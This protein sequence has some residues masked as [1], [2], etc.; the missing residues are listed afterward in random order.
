MQ[1]RT[2][3]AVALLSIAACSTDGDRIEPVGGREK[4]HPKGAFVRAAHRA[5]PDGKIEPGALMRMKHQRDAMLAAQ[6]TGSK[7][8]S[9]SVSGALT[10]WEWLGPG[11]VGGR[12]RG[13]VIHPNTPN[14][15]WVG[16]AGGGVWKTVDG[17]GTWLPLNDFLP[18]LAVGCMVM[19]PVD[20]DVIYVGTGEGG[21]F[22]TT[23]G[24]TNLAVMQG[25]GIFRTDDGGATFTQLASTASW[26][27]VSRIAVDPNDSQVLLAAT[28]DG[29][30]RTTDGGGAWT[31][32]STKPAMDVD[33][34]PTD[35]SKA[36]AGTDDEAL[37]SIDG[38]ASWLVA[39]GLPGPQTTDRVEI[40]YARSDPSIVFV[41]LSEGDI[42]LYRS[43]DGGASYA[44][45]Y[46]GN[47]I[48][49]YSKY[50]STMWV[51]PTDADVVV[52]GGVYPYRSTT[53]GTSPTSIIGSIHPDL[54][55]YAEHPNYDGVTN[56]TVYCSTDAGLWVTTNILA[57]SV[58]WNDLN[59]NLGITQFYG[60]AIH[61]GTGTVVG[62]TQDNGSQR[63]Q[64]ATDT[65]L[66]MFGGDGG[67]AASDPTNSNYFFGESQNLHIFRSTNG[68]LS[69]SYIYSSGS[70]PIIE[71]DP[72]FIAPFII[73]P[74]ENLRILAGGGELWRTNDNRASTV[75]WSSIKPPLNCSGEAAGNDDLGESHFAL[76]PPCNI[77]AIAVEPGNSDVI[78][79]G[80][81]NGQVFKTTNGTAV[82]PSWVDVDVGPQTLPGRFVGRI[83]IDPLDSDRVYVAFYG[84]T[85]DNLWLTEDGGVTWNSVTGAGAT[86]LPEAPVTSV[87]VHRTRA[88]IVYAGT[89]IGVYWSSDD[90]ATWATNNLGAGIA[91]IEELVWRNDDELMVVTHG[92]GI[93]LAHTL[94]GFE[95]YCTAG[96]SAAGCQATLSASGTPSASAAS[97]FQLQATGVEGNKDGLFFYGTNGRQLNPWGS[98]TSYQC[99]IPPVRRAG[100]LAATGTSGACDGSF[101][102]DLN[103]R[104]SAKPAHN[105]GSGAVVQAQ[106]WYRDPNNTSNQTT[107]LSDAIE[108]TV[109][110]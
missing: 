51:D 10:S 30:W 3:T 27:S 74:N 101:N 32:T 25:A 76:D 70:S 24:V 110:P 56:R 75:R 105:P 79:V 66:H 97:G 100:L 42:E 6:Q 1:R 93:Y 7:A 17:G 72:N 5:G 94:E 40:A 57:G 99:V 58:V 108:F 28:P 38:G 91:P 69:G 62:G 22:D 86:G 20:P 102:Q 13:H 45:R 82:A 12:L 14:T 104:W 31:Q 71:A 2:L 49:T 68:G 80:H 106:L 39:S 8:Y 81:N 89:D 77:S 33:F 23:Q 52:T 98:G 29:I 36:V 67:F 60:A 107:S 26:L 73:D 96:T 64:G 15:M 41:A 47:T 84:Y 4:H 9:A 34:H 61:D 95:S 37:Y 43:T 85:T 19:D 48:S 88:G 109:G 55:W 83:A 78:W 35:S 46:T 16:S 63:Y 44:A 18:T 53:G 50:N 103:A 65:W 59:N 54:H 90:G 87:A 11:N 21:Y 92:R